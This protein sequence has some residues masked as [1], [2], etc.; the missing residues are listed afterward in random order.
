MICQTATDWLLTADH[1]VRLLDAPPDV[2]AHVRGCPACQQV[3][4]RVARLD[5]AWR[6]LPVP[7]R[8]PPGPAARR[9]AGRGPPPPGLPGGAG[10]KGP[11]PPP[12]PGGGGGGGPRPRRTRPGRVSGPGGSTAPLRLLP[13]GAGRCPPAF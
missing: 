10:G 7:P 12:P 5:Q 1:P 8:G 13:A 2:A 9:P 4:T 11:A 6:E 3:M